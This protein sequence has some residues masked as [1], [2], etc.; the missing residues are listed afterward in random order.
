M[1]LVS[2]TA[3]GLSLAAVTVIG[4]V[5]T[6]EV[7]PRLSVTVNGMLTVPLKLGAGLNTKPAACS[8]VSAAPAT[9]GVTPSARYNTPWVAG[10]KAVTVTFATVP[11]AS[12]PASL[13]AIGVSSAPAAGIRV[14]TGA[15][16]PFTTGGGGVGTK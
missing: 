6:A 9:T 15:K 10:G 12:V 13:T 3:A 14:A 5:A 7:A 8:G 4:V 1:L 11:S 2:A 16:L